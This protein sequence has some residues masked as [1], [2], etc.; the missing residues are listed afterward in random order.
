[1][2]MNISLV[3]MNILTAHIYDMG[4]SVVGNITQSLCCK[5]SSTAT[6]S[7][8]PDHVLVCHLEVA[9]STMQSCF[10]VNEI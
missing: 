10:V 6:R 3:N 4:G 5:I 1:V 9:L 8:E 7:I 2:K